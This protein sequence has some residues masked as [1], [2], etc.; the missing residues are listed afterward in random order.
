MLPTKIG[1]K[2]CRQASGLRS[3]ESSEHLASRFQLMMHS[4]TKETV[5]CSLVVARGASK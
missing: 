3:A 4:E 5:V 2:G 1:V